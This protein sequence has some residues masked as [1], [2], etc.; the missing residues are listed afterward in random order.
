MKHLM[1]AASLLLAAGTLPARNVAAAP[2][3]ESARLASVP[4]SRLDLPW[5][6]ARFAAK[7]AEMQHGPFDLVFYGDSITQNYEMSGPEAWRNFLPVWT[8]YYGGRHALNLGFRG[9]TTSHLLWR[10]ENGEAANIQPKAAVVLIGANNFGRLHWPAPETEGGVEK[11]IAELR[12]RLPGT[13]ILII[14]VLPSIRS[15]WVTTNAAELNQALARR[16]RGGGEATFVDVSPLFLTGGRIDPARFIDPHL[17][18]PEPA[19]HP[20][21]QTQAQ[22]AAA[23]EPTLSAWLGDRPR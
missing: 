15:P 9:D 13:H 20:T 17:L 22:I 23:I 7:A 1:I 19:L 10:I 6:R 16:Y 14:G 2:P 18:P 12:R 11:I 5:W 21:A 8:K 3:A 4:L